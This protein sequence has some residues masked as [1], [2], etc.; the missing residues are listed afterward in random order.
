[1]KIMTHSKPVPK[2]ITLSFIIPKTTVNIVQG[3][4]RYTS[5]TNSTSFKNILMIIA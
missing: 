4:Y 1:M 2:D 5:A 3:S